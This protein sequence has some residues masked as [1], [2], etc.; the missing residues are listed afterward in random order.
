[1]GPPGLGRSFLGERYQH[2][3]D[4]EYQRFLRDSLSA[5]IRE[6]LADLIPAR[7]AVGSGMSLANINRRA[8]GPDGLV[9]LGLNPE[10]AVDR[11]IGLLR[12]ERPDGSPIALIANYAVHGTYLSGRNLE[13]SGDVQ[14]VVASYVE[15]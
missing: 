1:M 3:W 9:T 15:E 14:G 13:I 7:L 5:G 4:R 11:K 12:L 10:G 8:P 6:A 2:E